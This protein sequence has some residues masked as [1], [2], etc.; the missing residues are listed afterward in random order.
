V[1]ERE[2][3]LREKEAL[4]AGV[5]VGAFVAGQRADVD[6]GGHGSI[7]PV[8]AALCKAGDWFARKTSDA[9]PEW[10]AHR[11]GGIAELV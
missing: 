6:A 2:F 3:S 9:R 8:L 11:G 5:G 7:P 10:D 4:G 1:Q